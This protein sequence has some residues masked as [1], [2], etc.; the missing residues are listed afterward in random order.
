MFAIGSYP[1]VSLAAAR[2]ERDKARKL[3]RDG[4][5]PSHNRKTERIRAVYEGSN[6]FKAIAVEWLAANKPRWAPRSYRQRERVLEID[7]LPHVGALPMRQVT[8][9]HAHAVLR[10]IESRAPQMAVLARQCFSSISRLA[11]MTMRADVDIAYPLRSAVRVRATRHKTPLRV[12]Q[13]PAFFK[14]LDCSPLRFPTKAGLQLM[15]LT[16]AR[17]VEVIGAK[18]EEIDFDEAVWTIPVH[19]MKMRQP[20]AVPLPKQALAILKLL[21]AVSRSSEYL[22]PN[23]TNPRRGPRTRCLSR[24]S[25][26]SS[27][28]ANSLR[29][30]YGSLAEQYLVNKATIA[31]CLSDS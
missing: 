31:M 25:T 5:H 10:Q 21:R 29:T 30:G 6:T 20:H 16:L 26:P 1:E 12:N 19:R 28:P 13:I 23:H 8:P 22:I 2:D 17:P 24:P 11:I 4:I 18:W 15:W 3:V 7:I 27:T 9:A 14:A